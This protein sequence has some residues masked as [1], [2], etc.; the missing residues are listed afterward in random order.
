MS[1]SAL[2]QKSGNNSVVIRAPSFAETYPLPGTLGRAA[3]TNIQDSYEYFQ[4]VA[5]AWQQECCKGPWEISRSKLLDAVDNEELS[6][7]SAELGRQA[8]A[9]ADTLKEV[10]TAMVSLTFL[11]TTFQL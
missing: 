4:K 7:A 8:L 3:Y 11:R 5:K 6:S 10:H 1:S 2:V 9:L